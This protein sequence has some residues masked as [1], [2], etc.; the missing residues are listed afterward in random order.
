MCG[1]LFTL[2]QNDELEIALEGR[3][4]E[5]QNRFWLMSPMWPADLQKNQG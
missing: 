4:L 2:A 5:L 3:V 1:N